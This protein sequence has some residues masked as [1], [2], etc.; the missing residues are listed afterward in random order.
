M[1]SHASDYERIFTA[2]SRMVTGL[3][4][5]NTSLNLNPRSNEFERDAVQNAGLPPLSDLALTD[6]APELGT[7]SALMAQPPS[8][9]KRVLGDYGTRILASFFPSFTYSVDRT[10]SVTAIAERDDR[11]ATAHPAGRPQSNFWWTV[12]L[13]FAVMLGVAIYVAVDGRNALDLWPPKRSAGTANIN[14]APNE[15]AHG[16]STV[17]AAAPTRSSS[18]GFP[19]PRAYGIY[20][21]SEGRLTELDV[22][23]IKVPDP[24]IAISAT[25]STPSRA[26]LPAGQLQFVVYRRDIASDAPDHVAMRVIAQVVRALTFDPTGKPDVKKV[27]ASWVVRSNAYQMNVAPIAENP[28]MIMIRPEPA[29]FIFPAGRYALVLKNVAYD[30]TLD[31][32]TGD[33]A[34]CLERTDALG[35]PVYTE[36]RSP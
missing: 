35:A 23:P 9:R 36:C 32:P 3:Q 4:S 34:H 2:N 29:E 26:Y 18:L 14:P 15:E 20:A 10:V 31:G 16:T 13:V 17:A 24:R 11:H 28:E 6:G 5:K 30:F 25:I 21:V 7:Q 12:Q 8:H 27:D 19:R 33:T 1:S 22:L